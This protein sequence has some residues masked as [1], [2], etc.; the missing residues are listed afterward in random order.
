MSNV[1]LISLIFI[2]LFLIFS[3][4]LKWNKII[5]Q[6][7][8]LLHEVI[9]G[10]YNT[11]FRIRTRDYRIK[12]LCNLLNKNM[13][14]FQQSI[15]KR[16]NL[17]IERKHLISN[18]SHDL[19]TPLTSIIGYIELIQTND[20]INP[21]ERDDYLSIIDK[22]AKAL[23][24]SLDSFFELAKIEEQDFSI[25]NSEINIIKVIED[26]LISNYNQLNKANLTLSFN[27]P[28]ENLYV[29]GNEHAAERIIQNIIENAIKYGNDGQFVG[30]DIYPNDKYIQIDIWDKGKGIPEEELP[31]IFHRMYRGEKIRNMSSNGSG[32]GLT[33]AKQLVRK[34]GGKVKVTSIPY[35]KTT[36]SIYLRKP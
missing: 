17:D 31:N 21:K 26:V 13:D 7:N 27:Y 34:L 14:T 3:F 11:R 12:L 30:I 5:N 25:N 22:K 24:H 33:I 10:N 8:I 9:D 23:S 6:L 4:K 36:F 28:T 15:E 19:R 32:L 16:E 2:L 18:I 35:S 1:I 29:I 20:Y